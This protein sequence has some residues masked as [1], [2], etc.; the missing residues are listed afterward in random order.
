MNIHE[1]NA[2]DLCGNGT[3]IIDGLVVETVY[4]W[5]TVAPTPGRLIA[6]G[7]ISGSEQLMRKVRRANSAKL[8]LADGPVL[9]I[10]CEGGRNGVRWVK[11]VSS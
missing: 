4:Y 8:A 3:I 5:L 9:T 7:S 6:E 2:D 11:V 10:R 1:E